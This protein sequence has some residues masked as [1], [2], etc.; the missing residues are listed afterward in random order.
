[1][2]IRIL[3]ADDHPLLRQ[4]IATLIDAQPDMTMVAEASGGRE[5]VELFRLHQPDITLMDVQ[6]ADMNGIEAIIAIR[7]EFPAAKIIVLTTYAGDVLAQRALEAGARAYVL[8]G[9]L[10]DDTLETIRNVHQGQKR[11]QPEVAAE[12][13]DHQGEASL[14][15]REV[16]VLRLVA[17]GN[18]NKLIARHL[19]INDETVK[20]HVKN[21]LG[22]L[23][24]RDR[25]HAVTLGI[26]RGIMSL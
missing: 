14:T 21:I 7:E 10:R 9:L 24:A 20:S 25:T 1:M 19:K 2:T 6:M 11:I 15:A 16:E 8:K 17:T 12:L 3:C 5:A 13:A 26:R 22:K 18:S 4:G 23:G